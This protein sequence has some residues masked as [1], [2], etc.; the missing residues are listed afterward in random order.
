MIQ[1]V[2]MNLFFWKSWKSILQ[3]KLPYMATLPAMM[4]ASTYRNTWLI[5]LRALFAAY[6]MEQWMYAHKS[7]WFSCAGISTPLV[8]LLC[9]P[10]LSTFTFS[11]PFSTPYKS[12]LCLPLAN[13]SHHQHLPRCR[14][15]HHHDFCKHISVSFFLICKNFTSVRVSVLVPVLGWLLL[16]NVQIKIYM[17]RVNR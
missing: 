13:L 15:H 4:W 2:M 1:T 16:H 3:L 8:F 6:N 5:W 10:Q 17:V 14:C 11:Q 9:C 7:L 12:C